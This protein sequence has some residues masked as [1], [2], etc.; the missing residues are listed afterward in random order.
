MTLSFLQKS[1]IYSTGGLHTHHCIMLHLHNIPIQTYKWYQW[2]SYSTYHCKKFHPAPAD[3]QDYSCT[4]NLAQGWCTAGHIHHYSLHTDWYLHEC[5]GKLI[6]AKWVIDCELKTA[7]K[8]IT[9]QL[10]K[11]LDHKCTDNIT[12][13]LT[14]ALTITECNFV[15]SLEQENGRCNVHAWVLMIYSWYW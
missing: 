2:I 5:W 7:T 4:Q 12:N 6:N 1:S 15:C 10:S 8:I 9:N 13:V 11:Q 3:S 14:N